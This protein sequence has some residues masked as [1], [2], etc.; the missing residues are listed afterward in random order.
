M[1]PTALAFETFE[2]RLLL[3]DTFAGYTVASYMANPLFGTELS[4]EL[5]DAADLIDDIAQQANDAADVAAVLATEIPGLL[6]R[7]G[8][9][10]EAPTLGDV[11]GNA[12]NNF[13]S[14]KGAVVSLFNDATLSSATTPAALATALEALSDDLGG[15]VTLQVNLLDADPDTDGVQTYR[16]NTVDADTFEL[17]YNLEVLVTLTDPGDGDTFS[18]DPGRNAD[19]LEIDYKADQPL[20]THLPSIK[21]SS[22]YRIETVFGITADVTYD[23]D[24]DNDGDAD[25]NDFGVLVT[26]TSAFLRDPSFEAG[27]VADTTTTAIPALQFGFLDVR[28]DAGTAE[29]DMH[30]EVAFAGTI[31][32][33]GDMSSPTVE[34]GGDIEVLLP[35]SV[36][37]SGVLGG[38]G[39]SGASPSIRLYSDNPFDAVHSSISGSDDGRTAISIQ[40]QD[41]D[42]LNP[43]RNIDS[44]GLANVFSGLGTMLEQLQ[45]KAQLF[46]I[47]L[48][49]IDSTKISDLLEFEGP[50]KTLYEALTVEKN[51][52]REANFVSVQDFVT[53]LQTAL[54]NILA[55]YNTNPDFADIAAVVGINPRYE[56]LSGVPTLRF[57]I[58][59]HANTS[60]ADLDLD[61]DLGLDLSPVGEVALTG[62]L[63]MDASFAVQLTLGIELVEPPNV[64]VVTAVSPSALVGGV[65]DG[66]VAGSEDVEFSLV[67][68]GVGSVRVTL[69]NQDYGSTGALAAALETAIASAIGSAIASG[70]LAAAAPGP[71]VDVDVNAQG[72]LVV[73]SEALPYLQ[74]IN[75]GD[76]TAFAELGFLDG[77]RAT[78]SRLPADGRLSGNASFSLTVGG[79]APVA[80]S[81][82]AAET[83][84]FTT[85]EELVALLNTK[86]AAAG[87]TAV[88]VGEDQQ[89]DDVVGRRIKISA[90]QSFVR[91]DAA[92]AV[93]QADLGLQN[94]AVSSKLM[95]RG[96]G[97]IFYDANDPGSP[98]LLPER[99][100]SSSCCR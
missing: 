81:I 76:A 54:N 19:A 100:R 83:V 33:A 75:R 80:I 98:P 90:G 18:L 30:V 62:T 28:A 79:A 93:A 8:S 2:P 38:D 49:V 26:P 96:D 25:E 56:F 63:T 24:L 86:V 61:G 95:I 41:F 65:V 87:A 14:V 48:P 11:L 40:L 58:E 10:F 67:L 88:L 91:V 57:T 12:T 34:T 22:S 32:D 97:S 94:D 71:D 1:R 85:P 50:M 3:S 37:P 47:T 64:G 92:D 59:L 21:V 13:N 53:K 89:G 73:H 17:L 60:N 27:I 99:S 66:N 44:G 16:V 78:V 70:D 68:G 84:G 31:D 74:V 55:T 35:I 7:S 39:F 9:P 36:D 29:F 4:A 45:A 51:G 15:G 20:G 52:A 82:N 72:R 69:D 77:Q 43:F 6:D 42:K 46:G 5:M 23:S